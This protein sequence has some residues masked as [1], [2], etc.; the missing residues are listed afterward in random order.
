MIK[1]LLS[2]FLI[3]SLFFIS[4]EESLP[5][6]TRKELCNAVDYSVTEV[7]VNNI[8][9]KISIVLDVKNEGKSSN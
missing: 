6:E 2:L 4:C 8:D 9:N 5:K 3:F 1:K 7:S